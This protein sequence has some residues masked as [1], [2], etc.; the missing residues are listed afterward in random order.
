LAVA[1]L[2][3]FEVAAARAAEFE[4]VY[5]PDGDWA[6]LFGRAPGYLG[7]ELLKD[8]LR[9]GRYLTIDRWTDTAAFEAFKHEW[10]AEYDT[11]DRLCESLTTSETPLGAFEA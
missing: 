5:G 4:R 9:P 7:T 8:V 6:R 10:K 11:L 2:W 1:L 3:T